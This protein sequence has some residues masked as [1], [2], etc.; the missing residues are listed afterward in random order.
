MP[1]FECP[2]RQMRAFI[3][4]SE[5]EI[6]FLNSMKRDHLVVAAGSE[7]IH[8][9]QADAE[10]FTLFSGWAFRYKSLPDG[11]RHILNFLLPGDFIGLQ[12]SMFGAALHGVE[13]LTAV[14]LCVFPRRRVWALFESMPELAFE[15]TWLGAREESLVDENLMSVGLRNATER[16]AALI[17]SLYKRCDALGLV[18][19]GAFE[20]PLNQTHIAEALG[21]SLVHTNKTLARL[22]RLGLFSRQNGRLKLENPRVLER[23]AQHFDDE[24]TPRPLL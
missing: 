4:K 16:V 19:D 10:L 1:C 22:R 9:E 6:A 24:V 5:P 20:F 21:L 23:L 7:I 12:A 11:R 17:I 13:A 18:E 15:A 3:K 14:E 8:P 2:L